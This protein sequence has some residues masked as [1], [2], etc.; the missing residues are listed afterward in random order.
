MLTPEQK[1][2]IPTELVDL[3]SDLSEYILRNIARRIAEGAKITETAEYQ[4][5]RARS[6]GFSTKEITAKI[7]E[8]NNIAADVIEDLIRSAAEQSDEFD[9]RMLGAGS[10]TSVSLEDNKEL[11]KLIAAQIKETNGKCENLTN[12]LGFADHDFIGRVYYLSMTDMYRKELDAAHMKVVT[13]ATDYTTAIRQAVNKLAASGVRTI[14]Y[15]S[16][17]SRSVEAAVRTALMTSV[18]HVAHRVSEQ[19]GEVFG[20][21]GWEMSAHSGARPSHA[22]YQGRQYTQEEYEQKIRSLLDEPNCRHD[23]YPIILGISQPAYTEEELQ[24]IDPPP[25]TYEGK[26]Y[27][28]YEAQQQMRKMEREMRKQKNRCIVADAAGDK[29]AFATASIRLN[30]QKYFYENFAQAANCYTEYERAFVGG[31]TKSMAMK[32]GVAAIKKEYNII[33][34]TLDKKD[35]P[36]L[37]EFKK[38]LYNNSDEYR[39]LRH[40]FNDKVIHSDYDDI[41]HLNGCLSDKVTRQWYV[42]H[43]KMIPD[44]IDKTKSIEDQARQAHA[45]RNQFRTNAR[46]LMLNQDERKWLDE[47]HPNLTFEEQIAKKM[48]DKGMTRDE[49]IL[50]ILATASKSNKKVNEKFEL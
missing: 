31:F 11:Q 19:N 47:S 37:D 24:N 8:I 23:V 45:L 15:E 25:F 28:A 3:Y 30:R 6:L 21:N 42:L 34:K 12:T 16:G 29:E 5:Y 43:D 18:S 10:D 44:M 40:Q 50:D 27:T 7:A 20:A 36:S 1:R 49:A 9:R 14:D 13:G 32:S 33:A 35:V 26:R 38:M 2:N 39:Q 4:L 22:V 46:D 41:K 48:S 17:T